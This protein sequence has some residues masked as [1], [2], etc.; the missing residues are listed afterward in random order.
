MALNWSYR[1]YLDYMDEVDANIYIYY[2]K[3]KM[4]MN[5]RQR[6]CQDRGMSIAT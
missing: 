3:P 4:E 6:Y 1:L 2:P 5:Q